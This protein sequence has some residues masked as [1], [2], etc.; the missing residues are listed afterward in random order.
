[1]AFHLAGLFLFVSLMVDVLSF[2]VLGAVHRRCHRQAACLR[3]YVTTG[4]HC[5][6][7][8][9]NSIQKRFAHSKA[10]YMVRI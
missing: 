4:R 3:Q 9:I 7:C 1:M 2:G 5:W 6:F 8:H 10:I